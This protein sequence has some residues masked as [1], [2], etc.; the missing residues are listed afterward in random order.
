[1][2]LA[3]SFEIRTVFLNW[4]SRLDLSESKLN[5]IDI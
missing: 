2:Y 5:I 3:Y 4:K 1:M